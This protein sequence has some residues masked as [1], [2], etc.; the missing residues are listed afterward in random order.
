MHR[1]LQRS[2]DFAHALPSLKGTL[3]LQEQYSLA[4]PS[5]AL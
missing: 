1:S 3:A 2:M 4:M 5:P